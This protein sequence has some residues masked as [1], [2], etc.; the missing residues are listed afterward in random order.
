MRVRQVIDNNNNNYTLLFFSRFHFVY[1]FF[2]FMQDFIN[3][4]FF[5]VEY[6]D[7][8]VAFCTKYDKGSITFGDVSHIDI[9]Y[10][11]VSRVCLG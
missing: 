5:C 1:L 7:D 10:T 4:Y 3:T 9:I 2:T 6:V 11:H 8:K